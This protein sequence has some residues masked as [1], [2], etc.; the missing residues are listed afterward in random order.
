MTPPRTGVYTYCSAS[1]GNTCTLTVPPAAVSDADLMDP[2]D[3]PDA[4]LT[5]S[6]STLNT[7]MQVQGSGDA[8]SLAGQTVTVRGVVTILL[9]AF[10]GYGLQDLNGD[11]NPATSDGIFV[12]TN[13]TSPLPNLNVGDLIQITGKVSEYFNQTQITATTFTKLSTE[14]V[15]WQRLS[16]FAYDCCSTRERGRHAG[17][18]PASI[19]H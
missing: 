11:G 10:R 7:I 12:F 8:T 19:D 5:L 9:P 13:S 3:N 6:F 16:R 2:P 15:Q 17:H 4:E 1:A 18:L 14:P